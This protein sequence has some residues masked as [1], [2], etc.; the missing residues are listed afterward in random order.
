VAWIDCPATGGALGRGI[1]SRG[2]HAASGP[3]TI[4]KARQGPG[5][6]TDLPGFVLNGSTVRAF[7]ALYRW[8][9]RRKAGRTTIPYRAFFYPL[10]AIGGWNRMY[11]KRGLYQYQSVVPP[12]AARDATRAML[13]VIA[14]AGEGSF[15]A[16]LKTFGNKP[17]PGMLSFPMPGTTLA[18]D[19]A[20]RGASTLALM[21]RL[22]A[23]VHEAGGRLYPAKDGRIP[24]EMFRV[25]YPNWEDFSR[26]VDP[27]FSS[28][29]W[30]R[31]SQG[32]PI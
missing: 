22:D 19:F 10:D 18:L 27:G 23:I 28:S 30:R 32:E 1:F 4:G 3:L 13:A 12:E 8:N 31:V 20:N 29:F 15:L 16:V 25:G 21:E 17:S 24:P 7:N 26:Y 14:A 11:G 9:G 2:N 5:L 6:P